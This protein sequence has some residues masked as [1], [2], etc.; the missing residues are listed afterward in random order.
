MKKT[1]QAGAA[2][3][4]I[5]FS[6]IACSSKS[7]DTRVAP[8]TAVVTLSTT[9]TL[10]TGTQIFAAQATVNLPA[11]VTAKAGPSASNAQVMVTDAGV[12]TA[13][14]QATG[15]E[16]I[17][18][19]YVT[20]SAPSTYKVKISVGK[21]SGF[22]TGDFATVKCDVAAGSFPAATDFTITDFEAF[23]QYGAQIT[24]L[25]PGYTVSIQ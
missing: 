8:T 13:S 14:G 1:L 20:G 24:G 12:V 11:G 6:L 7:S 5:L 18:A 23:D 19:T 9:G 22:A 17:L 10:N 16:V 3:V 25:T 2:I 4:L 15:A 21:S